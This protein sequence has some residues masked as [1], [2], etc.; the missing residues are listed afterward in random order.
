MTPLFTQRLIYSAILIACVHILF[1]LLKLSARKTQKK[2]G[3]RRSRYLAIRR[4]ITMASTGLTLALLL[5]LWDISF[6]NIWIAL[7]SI[8]AVTAIAF[9]AI[10]S[11]VGNILAGILL[12]FTS[13]FKIDDY[14]EIMP[15]GIEGSV[16]AINT[17]YTVLYDEEENRINVPNSLFFQKYIRVKKKPLERPKAPLKEKEKDE[18]T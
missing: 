9:F 12:Y 10:W 5:L 6:K 8:L 3:I 1:H 18:R 2:F 17:F 16:M 14:I 4:I 13:P 7:S 15:D 11:L